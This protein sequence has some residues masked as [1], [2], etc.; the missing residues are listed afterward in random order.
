MIPLTD[1]ETVYYEKQKLCHICKKEFCYD[2]NDKNKFKLYQNVRDHCHY[3]G[4]FR[5]AAHSIC[6]LRYKVPQEIPVKIHNGS[7]YD[8]HFIIK[9]L[10]EEF[11]SQF[12]CLGENTAKHITFSVPI[13]KENE[14]DKRITCKIKFIDTCRF[15]Q[16]KLWDLADN[17]SQTNNKD[18]KKCLERNKIRSEC[19]FFG[20]KDNRLKY[21][22]KKCNDTSAKS[23]DDLI[24]KFPTT[25]KFCNGNLNKFVLLLRKCIYPYEYMDSWERFIETS[26]PP[27]KSIYSELNLE[28]ISDK[29]YLHTQNVWDIFEIRNLGEYHDLFVQ[30]DTLLLADVYEKFMR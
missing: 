30:T 13:K 24:K 7:K 25:Y 14:D 17:L 2:K 12:E 10:A 21:K 1:K 8:Y 5:G 29:D 16:S 19:Q 28:D 11:K 6:N 9:E 20:L 26:L 23:V 18:C 27:K 3:T 4:K 15:M 22:C